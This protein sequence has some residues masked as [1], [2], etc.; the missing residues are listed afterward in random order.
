[1][2][3]GRKVMSD[4]RTVDGQCCCH[5]KIIIAALGSIRNIKKLNQEPVRTLFKASSSQA[6]YVCTLLG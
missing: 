5:P 3:S 2:G 6:F 1:M 4:F